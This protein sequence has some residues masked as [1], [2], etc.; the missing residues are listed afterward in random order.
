MGHKNTP[1]QQRVICYGCGY[2]I[3]GPVYRTA[4]HNFHK[5][6]QRE[7]LTLKHLMRGGR[8]VG[9]HKKRVY[10]HRGRGL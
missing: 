2:E 9:I 7:Y 8:N 1:G 10:A 5:K 4:K 6:C 3:I